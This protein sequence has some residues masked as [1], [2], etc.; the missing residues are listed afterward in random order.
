MKF[1][2]DECVGPTVAKWLKQNNYDALSVYDDLPGIDDEAVLRKAVTE[3]RILI[4]S[5]KDFGEMIFK[6]K[7]PHC[8]ILLLRLID[9]KPTNK[10]RILENILENYHQDLSDNFVVA[11]EKIIRI[12]KPSMH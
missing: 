10:I 4:T 11:T 12:I 1:L 5:D 7:M 6:N 3:N 8:G 9:E 2:V